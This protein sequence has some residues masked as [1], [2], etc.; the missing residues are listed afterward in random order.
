MTAL[1]A[2]MLA[3]KA[4]FYA[5][6]KLHGKPCG[7]F[8]QYRLRFVSFDFGGGIPY[9]LTSRHEESLLALVI[10]K[11]TIVVRGIS[12]GPPLAG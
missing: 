1:I 6:R 8:G 10:S 9:L 3:I 11:T 7:D 4:A 12:H 5:S 2:W